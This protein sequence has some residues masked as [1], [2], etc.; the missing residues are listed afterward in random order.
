M[1]LLAH[2]EL[3]NP[4]K[5]LLNTLVRTSPGILAY[6]VIIVIITICWGTGFFVLLNSISP[7]FKSLPDSFLEMIQYTDIHKS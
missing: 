6:F 5:T 1:S 3:F 4:A 7:H 2:Y